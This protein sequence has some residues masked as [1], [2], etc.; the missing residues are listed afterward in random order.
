MKRLTARRFAV[1][2]GCCLLLLVLAV[3]ISPGVGTYRLGL[4][5]AW[6]SYFAGDRESDLYVIAFVLRMPGTV[7]ALVAGAT[8]AMCGA[9]FQ[10]L[11]RNPLATP[12]T[13]GIAS[14]GSLGAL[15]A[16][17]A[18]W[19]VTV[20]GLSSVSFSAFAG[21]AA[22]LGVVVL[23]ARSSRR[24]SGNALLLAGVT[25]GFFCSA[26]MMFVTHLASVHDT[27]RIVRW[28]MGSLETVGQVEVRALLVILVPVWIV[29]FLQA[30]NLN[31]FELGDEVSATRGVNPAV[32]QGL[33]LGLASLAVAAVVSICGPVGFVGLI[34]PH[35]VRLV[36]GPDNRIVLPGSALIGATFL[37]VCDW[38]TELLPAWYGQ[39]VSREMAASTIPIGVMTALLGAPLFLWILR[40]RLK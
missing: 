37:I 8:L 35:G 10:T 11:F 32:L 40:S 17:S 12:Y 34:V 33:C 31:Q 27:F 21:S 36:F 26:M 38:L 9:V 23:L 19:R 39:L 18:G 3:A 24:L 28:M 15:I 22:V 30:P 25:I 13:L 5:E 20:L 29:L 6:R 2:M 16:I 7:K 14:G 1:A 4:V